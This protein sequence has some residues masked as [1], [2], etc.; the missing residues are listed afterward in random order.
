MPKG[1]SMIRRFQQG[2]LSPLF[3]RFVFTDVSSIKTT[4]SGCFDTAGMRCLNQ[5]SHCRL[6]SARRRWVAS[7]DSFICVAKLAEKLA[8]SV[9]VRPNVRRVKKS[10]TQLGHC[11]VAILRDDFG[12][13]VSMRVQFA[14]AFWSALRRGFRLARPLY[15]KRPSHSRLGRKLQAQCRRTTA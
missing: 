7:S 2:G 10:G 1:A 5:S 13:E 9:G 15:R 11:D 6:T 3:V 8:N 12:K 4:R 14:P